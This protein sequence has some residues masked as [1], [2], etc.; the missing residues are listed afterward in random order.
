MIQE[1]KIS[2]LLSTSNENIYLRCKI[3]YLNR[4]FTHRL[5]LKLFTY[6]FMMVSGVNLCYDVE[7]LVCRFLVVKRTKLAMEWRSLM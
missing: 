4:Y 3:R 2:F 1:Q 7:Y 6:L 5:N